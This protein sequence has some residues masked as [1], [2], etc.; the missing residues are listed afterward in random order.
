MIIYVYLP[1]NGWRYMSYQANT[2]GRTFHGKL[3]ITNE[4]GLAIDEDMPEF[5][6][7]LAQFWLPYK[8]K[9]QQISDIRDLFT[10]A[11][12]ASVISEIDRDAIV[13]DNI[14]TNNVLTKIDKKHYVDLFVKTW[15]EFSVH[16]NLQ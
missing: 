13:F 1:P 2:I 7:L 3:F 16:N 9:L 12:S 14:F 4:S 11:V 15:I 8:N 10:V 5:S 6:S